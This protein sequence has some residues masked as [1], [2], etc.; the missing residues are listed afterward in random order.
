M[1]FSLNEA[2]Y[3]KGQN[4]RAP[5]GDRDGESEPGLRDVS[6]ERDRA[7]YFGNENNRFWGRV[8]RAGVLIGVCYLLVVWWNLWTRLLFKILFLNA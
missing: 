1:E 8:S 3:Y 4:Q 6:A 5:Q 7:E 2:R